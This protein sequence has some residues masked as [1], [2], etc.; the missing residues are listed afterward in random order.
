MYHD[1]PRTAR[2][3]L[4]LRACALLALAA[5]LLWGGRALAVQLQADADA[6]AVQ[7]LRRS[8]LDAAVQCYAVEGSYP[9][10][11]QT[12]EQEYGVQINHEQYI[13]TYSAYASNLLPE[14]AVLRKQK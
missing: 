8:V 13:V 1:K 4:L 7:A 9:E 6:Q 2:R 10:S 5:A 14:V 12:L 3:V 11:L